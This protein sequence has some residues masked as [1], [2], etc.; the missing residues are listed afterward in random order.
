M[1]NSDEYVMTFP[2]SNGIFGVG[3]LA[4]S[5]K[6]LVDTDQ[7]GPWHIGQWMDFRHTAI[8]VRFGSLADRERARQSCDSAVS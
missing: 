6:A 3:R 4:T 8:R 5:L 7:I 2:V 1:T